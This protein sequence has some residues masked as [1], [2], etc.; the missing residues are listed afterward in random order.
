MTYMITDKTK[1]SVVDADGK[2][3][4]GKVVD[5]T[6]VTFVGT[7]GVA[8]L[9]AANARAERMGTYFAVVADN[10]VS[11]LS[12]GGTG[13][14]VGIRLPQNEAKITDNTVSG[15]ANPAT[16]QAFNCGTNEIFV[17]NLASGAGPG[18]AFVNC[19]DDGGNVA[20]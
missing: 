11:G 13:Y 12:N 5:L 16:Q 3:T 15:L 1:V 18:L 14:S 19:T 20:R 7:A 2:E 9:I 10:H 17:R 4:E 8:A 6:R